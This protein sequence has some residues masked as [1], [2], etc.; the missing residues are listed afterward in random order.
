MQ[1]ELSAL[2]IKGFSITLYSD[3]IVMD[4]FMRYKYTIDED[5]L[6]EEFGLKDIKLVCAFKNIKE[7][8]GWNAA[9][10]L[11]KERELAIEKGSVFFFSYEGNNVDGLLRSLK[12]VDIKGIGLRRE[13]GFG[14]VY[15]CD[16][17]HI[18]NLPRNWATKEV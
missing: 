17:F 7:V 8:L 18:S 5:S 10:G 13:E 6:M 9:W 3:V 11:P 2:N 16:S 4:K 12:D 1:K 15:I 14:K